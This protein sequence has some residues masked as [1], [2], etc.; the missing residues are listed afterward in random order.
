MQ[1]VHSFVFFFF[2]FGIG[3][4]NIHGSDSSLW[5]TNVFYTFRVSFYFLITIFA[6]DINSCAFVRFSFHF[7]TSFFV[8]LGFHFFFI[9][10]FSWDINSLCFCTFGFSFYHNFVTGYKSI[11]CC[12]QCV[13]LNHCNIFGSVD[14]II[15]LTCEK[16]KC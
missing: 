1:H 9:K 8:C 11:I 2:F 14:G 15:F 13:I 16:P 7:I 5:A 6:W 4:T 10:F 3:I 12:M